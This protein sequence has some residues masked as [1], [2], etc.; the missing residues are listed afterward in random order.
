VGRRRKK[1]KKK[2][3]KISGVDVKNKN[4]VDLWRR[5]ATFGAEEEVN[6]N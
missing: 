1:K 4:L 6:E 3:K 5:Q 2:K